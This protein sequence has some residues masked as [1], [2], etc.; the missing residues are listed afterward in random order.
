MHIYGSCSWV[1]K[2]CKGMWITFS[3]VIIS[4]K[5]LNICYINP[6]IVFQ[7]YPEYCNIFHDKNGTETL[8]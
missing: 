1:E 6:L 2:L 4:M 3:I 7:L 5:T 8:N